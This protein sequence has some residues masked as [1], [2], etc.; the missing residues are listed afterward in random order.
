M[1]V[2]LDP[3]EEERNVRLPVDLTDGVAGQPGEQGEAALEKTA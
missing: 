2:L 1:E 3:G